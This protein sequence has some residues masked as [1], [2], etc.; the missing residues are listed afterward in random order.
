VERWQR[1]GD[2]QSILTMPINAGYYSIRRRLRRRLFLSAD[3]HL[4][5]YLRCWVGLS[6]FFGDGAA[7]SRPYVDRGEQLVGFKNPVTVADL[8]VAS[9]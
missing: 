6:V 4:F 7:K 8:A 3:V 5:V 2:Y 1:S 9:G